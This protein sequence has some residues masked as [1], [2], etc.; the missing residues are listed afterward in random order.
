VEGVTRAGS[1]AH[2][3]GGRKR[4][5]TAAPMA[6]P[7][8]VS[9]HEMARPPH[10][11]GSLT[12]IGE[13]YAALAIQAHAAEAPV[14]AIAV[15]FGVDGRSQA[16][17]ADTKMNS[18]MTKY[19]SRAYRMKGSLES[20]KRVEHRLDVADVSLYVVTPDSVSA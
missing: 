14:I 15:A 7:T 19:T 8:A 9:A 20:C 4:V 5:R 1:P 11:S 12:G 2:A 17:P 10:H 3:P 18:R 6:T 16:M 13:W